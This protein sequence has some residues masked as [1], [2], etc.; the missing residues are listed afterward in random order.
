MLDPKSK[1]MRVKK[2]DGKKNRKKRVTKSDPQNFFESSQSRGPPVS[3]WLEPKAALN[4][5]SVESFETEDRLKVDL[6]KGDCFSNTPIAG[7]RRI[8]YLKNI[9]R[10]VVQ[11]VCPRAF[12]QVT[13]GVQRVVQS[14]PSPRVSI[15]TLLG[16]DWSHS[17]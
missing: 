2:D 16:L 13:G 17:A 6:K 10:G 9:P 12:V 11:G 15:G 1:K 4:G 5:G 7:G 3:L 14:L 8:S